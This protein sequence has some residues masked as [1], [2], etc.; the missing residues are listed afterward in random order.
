MFFQVFGSVQLYESCSSCVQ[1]YFS[2]RLQVFAVVVLEVLMTI[3]GEEGQLL[4]RQ[5]V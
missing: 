3:T 5:V 2:C 4:D 1:T